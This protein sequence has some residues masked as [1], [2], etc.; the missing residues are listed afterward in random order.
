MGTLISTLCSSPPSSLECVHLHVCVHVCT[1]T[2]VYVCA[3]V[4]KE[5]RKEGKTKHEFT[6]W[7]EDEIREDMGCGLG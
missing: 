4:C 5:A 2:H 3:C 1:C 7:F 6:N